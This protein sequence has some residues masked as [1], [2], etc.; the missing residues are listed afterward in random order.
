MS[1]NVLIPI[2][3][4]TEELEAVAVINVL[5]RAGAHVVVA[6]VKSK[7]ITAARGVKLIADSLLLDCMATSY[8]LIVLPGGVPGVK[9]LRDSE[10]LK[11]LLKQQFDTNK[12]IG[13]ICAAP[14]EVL[15][16]H[17]ILDQQRATGHPEFSEGIANQEVIAERVVVD[18]NLVTS[19]GAGTAIEFAL[20]LVELLFGHKKALE[21]AEKMVAVP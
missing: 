17:G 13:A 7:T 10:A 4:G 8:D 16:F 6:G 2:A 11:D 18:G 12:M 5:R 3:D 19:R 9:N 20:K 14:Q 1:I 15:V 21:V